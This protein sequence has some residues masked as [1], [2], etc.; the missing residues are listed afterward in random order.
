MVETAV[1]AS[2]RYYPAF[3]LACWGDQSPKEVIHGHCRRV[4]SLTCCYSN[5]GKLMAFDD[6]AAR[7]MVILAVAKWAL[8]CWRVASR[9]IPPAS[10]T[11]V[12]LHLG[13][14]SRPGETQHPHSRHRRGGDRGQAGK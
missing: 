11:V 1:L 9:G 7:G 6:I 10:V 5:R 4:R 14:G 3:Q 12:D 8:Q 2:E 13:T